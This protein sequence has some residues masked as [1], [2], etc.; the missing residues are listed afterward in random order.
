VSAGA[1]PILDER[2]SLRSRPVLDLLLAGE[3]GADVLMLLVPD[4]PDRQTL[5]RVR[6]PQAFRVLVQAGPQVAGASDVVAAVGAAEHVDEGHLARLADDR[7]HRH[8]PAYGL[9]M[10]IS[11]RSLRDLLDQRD[12]GHTPW[13]RD[14]LDQREARSGE[15]AQRG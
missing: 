2:T 10:E 1:V 7:P 13:L 3:R 5:A 8:A 9:W 6:R 11:T 4:K 12:P 15:D 14:L